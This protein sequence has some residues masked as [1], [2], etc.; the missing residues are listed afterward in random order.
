M[1]D[2]G[3]QCLTMTTVANG[4]ATYSYSEDGDLM[5]VMYINGNRCTFE[6]DE[7]SRLSGYRAI[8]PVGEVV[9]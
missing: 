5:E 7:C 1:Y 8:S 6:Y 9:S 4:S 2:S 3:E